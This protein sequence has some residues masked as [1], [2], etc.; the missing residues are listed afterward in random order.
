MAQDERH[1]GRYN[2]PA[3]SQL[4]QARQR[5][6]PP[7]SPTAHNEPARPAAINVNPTTKPDSTNEDA[8]ELLEPW[9]AWKQS[10]VDG[11]YLGEESKGDR[12]I[13]R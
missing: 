1:R 12:L 4:V 7:Q 11:E 6:C 9:I 2:D 5:S 13:N 3:A 8:E 10:L